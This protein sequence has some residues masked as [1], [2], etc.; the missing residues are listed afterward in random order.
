MTA[1]E[2]LKQYEEAERR[3]YYLRA[4]YERE[5]KQID[6]IRSP[7]GSDGTPRGSGISNTVE[8]RVLRLIEKAEKLIEAQYEAVR[9]EQDVLGVI[10]QVPGEK[11]SVLYERYI[12]LKRWEDVAD[13]MH[14]SLRQIHNLHKEALQIVQRCI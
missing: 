11:G 14:Y 6:L 4:A 9:I 12:N 8:D 5:R 10:M 7:L 1:K 2:Y 13:I 3:V